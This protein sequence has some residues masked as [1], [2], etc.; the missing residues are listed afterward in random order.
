MNDGTMS[1]AHM[2]LY[3]Y[4]GYKS[5]RGLK[6]MLHCFILK[7]NDKLLSKAIAPVNIFM[8]YSHQSLPKFSIP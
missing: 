2:C 5:K 4:Q 7:N 6:V 8:L 3:V 1:I